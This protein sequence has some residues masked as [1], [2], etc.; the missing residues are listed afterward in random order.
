[1][2]VI[3][4]DAFAAGNLGDAWPFPIGPECEVACGDEEH[5]VMCP[6]WTVG[7]RLGPGRH[8][9][10]SPDPSRPVAAYFVSF[11]AVD[12]EFDMITRFA[13]PS[14]RQPIWIRASGSVLVRCSDPGVLIAQFIG[15]P[16]DSIDDGIR[17]SV[18]RSVERMVARLLTRRVVLAG[19]ISAITE[20]S[21][22]PEILAEIEKAVLTLS[23]I[24]R[25]TG[26]NAAAAL[27][28]QDSEESSSSKSAA[29]ATP[30]GRSP[31][32]PARPERDRP[33][34]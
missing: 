31:Q 26:S 13:L 18:S 25:N 30:G 17:R 33:Q 19:T 32:K 9:W 2:P 6:A 8:L 20:P 3:A 14:T 15:L 28:A 21:L 23:G 7:D 22:L 1:M 11:G 12:V 5:V 4:R 34:A 16:F 27:E 24:Q 29:S 10:R